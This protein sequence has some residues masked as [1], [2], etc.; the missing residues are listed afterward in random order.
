MYHRAGCGVMLKVLSAAPI[1]RSRLRSLKTEINTSSQQIRIRIHDMLKLVAYAANTGVLPDHFSIPDDDRWSMTDYPNQPG[2]ASLGTTKST[3]TPGGIL[4]ISDP[5]TSARH[6]Y[7]RYDTLNSTDNAIFEINCQ[8]NSSG[9]SNGV[10]FGFID[11]KKYIEAGLFG[12]G[13]I[14]VVGLGLSAAFVTNDKFHT[15][16]I[17]KTGEVKMEVF[18]DGNLVFDIPYSELAVRPAEF[19]EY[20]RQVFATSSPELSEWDITYVSYSISS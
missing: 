10:A 11:T 16:R 8:L 18:A 17:V 20:Q 4:H 13:S 7:A 19:P 9:D 3:I 5:D 6:I 1:R 12:N 14:F 15:Y 2:G